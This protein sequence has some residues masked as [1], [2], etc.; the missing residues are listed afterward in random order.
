MGLLGPVSH[1]FRKTSSTMRRALYSRTRNEY[2]PVS[3]E[4]DIPL[5][6]LTNNHS[7][8]ND[9][10]TNQR[11][12]GRIQ[13]TRKGHNYPRGTN[14][15][16]IIGV[17]LIVLTAAFMFFR[18]FKGADVPQCRS[19]YMY[20]SYAR[21]DGFDKRFTPLAQKYHLYLYREQDK[22]Q[23]PIENDAI[24]LNGIPTLFIPGNA[25][26]FKQ[27]RSIASACANLFFDS[28]ES[29][30]NEYSQNID[31]FAAD[32]NEDFTAFHGQT[33]LDQAEYLNDAIAYIL[34]LYEQSHGKSDKPLP[35]SVI[36]VA[37]S[38]GGIVARV[39]PTLQNHVP[40]SMNT[41]LTLSS[42]HA[43]APVTFDGDILKIYRKV[44]DYWRQQFEDPESFFSK[45]VSLISITGSIQDTVLPADYAAVH[46]II[47]LQN[48]FTT[49]TTTIP[50]VW[51]PIDHLAVVWCKQL[52]LVLA[53]LLLEIVDNRSPYKTQNLE[54]RINVAK[55]LLLSGFEEYYKESKTSYKSKEYHIVQDHVDVSIF[56]NLPSNQPLVIRKGVSPL[57]SEHGTIVYIPKDIA[58]GT[59]LNVISSNRF[60]NIRLC[61][62]RAELQCVS[63]DDNVLMTPRSVISTRFA[64]DSSLD[65]D[66]SPFWYLKVSWEDLIKFDLVLIE[67]IESELFN[68]DDFFYSSF[69]KESQDVTQKSS[70]LDILT[71]GNKISLHS[72][73]HISQV[74]IELPKLTDALLSYKLNIAS[75][76]LQHKS[77]LFQ[78]F[79]RQ[80]IPSPYETKWH[81]NIIENNEI[82]INM[83]NVAPFI[84][85]NSRESHS[86]NLNVMLP[87]NADVNISLHVNWPLTFK[88]LFIRYRLAIG[89]IPV[90]FVAFVLAIQFY[91]FGKTGN[92][93]E[94]SY[95]MRNVLNRHF[96]VV[97][98]GLMIITPILNVSE[99][100]HLLY[101]FDPVKLNRPFVL[102]EKGILTNF[103]FLG[104]RDWLQSWIGLLFGLMSLGVL[105]V[106]TSC[107]GMFDALITRLSSKLHS[108]SE[109]IDDSFIQHK[110]I[111]DR[112]RI[113]ACC[114]ILFAVMFYIP[115]QLAYVISTIIQAGTCIRVVIHRQRFKHVRT[116]EYRN[117]FNYNVSLLILFLFVAIINTPVIIV[118]LHNLSIGYETTFRSHHNIVAITPIILL[119]SSNSTFNIP[120]F[121]KNSFDWRIC[122]GL[123]AYLSFFSIVYGTRNLYFIHDIVNIICGWLFYGTVTNYM[124]NGSA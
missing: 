99:I 97:C 79:I 53:K 102:A 27:V 41:I 36:I 93:E 30:E 66:N 107:I 12:S 42:P 60:P 98:F 75:E 38:M 95:V 15:P 68:D 26:S 115:Y 9:E 13:L 34:S 10:S 43:A 6:D 121:P 103:Y 54:G 74:N 57:K 86:L 117:L 3:N 123:F 1:L 47:P 2:R 16:S 62:E 51:T 40:G 50:G 22:D 82:D 39:M 124:N 63:M 45:N 108:S 71:K 17:L 19:I 84:P 114:I 24:Q 111:F 4:S 105:F 85:L 32:F 91:S 76:T 21:V 44:N 33:M 94:F 18:D 31:F 8:D 48:G 104:I 90:A 52:R 116:R 112:K 28:P 80:W 113:I 67:P 109:E 70:S 56:D 25:G 23:E 58:Q 101:F 61:S 83:H 120:S 35:E 77:L 119:V 110:K 72:D 87:P 14:I 64:A 49:Y 46:D 29:I 7:V 100:Q 69:S 88:M 81:M 122:Y 55:E 37:H 5:D 96:L 106:I 73:N 20:P 59:A 118:F 65:E 11:D 89:S 78:P 92:F